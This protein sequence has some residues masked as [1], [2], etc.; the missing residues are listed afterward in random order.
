[1]PSEALLSR[2]KN[3]PIEIAASTLEVKSS[4]DYKSNHPFDLKEVKNFSQALANPIAVFESETNSDRT[5]VLTELKD[6]KGNNFIAILNIARDKGRNY[7]II[8][9][10]ISLYPKESNIHIAKWFLGKQSQDVGRDLLKWVDKKKALNWLA[11]NVSNVRSV[12][13][14]NKSATKVGN[15]FDLCKEKVKNFYNPQ[16]IRTIPQRIGGIDI[17][18]DIA[19]QAQNGNKVRITGV[20]SASG[21][22]TNAF[23]EK[24]DNYYILSYEQWQQPKIALKINQNKSNKHGLKL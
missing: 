19:T 16:I 23:L 8:N 21:R 11:N 24:R 3:L 20:H 9:S 1:M 22:Q 18:K 15:V 14:P 5:V 7:N 6:E 2:L 12:G 13:I 10:I 17:T 4:K